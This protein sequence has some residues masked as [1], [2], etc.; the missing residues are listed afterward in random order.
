MRIL[1]VNDKEVT[2]PDLEKGYLTTETIV[3]AHHDAV[4]AKAGKS[5]V[6]VVREYDNGGKDVITVWDEKPVQAKEA[7]DETEEIQRYHAYTENELAERKKAKEESENRQ[8][9]LES[10]YNADMTFS[11]VVDA[12][13][14][15]LYGGAE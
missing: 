9:K 3:I 14:G 1:D 8:K 13:A 2:N 6:E 7:Y 4:E 10:L 11:D 5:H 15:I 12:V